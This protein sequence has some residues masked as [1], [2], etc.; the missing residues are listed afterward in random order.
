MS[1]IK[2]NLT[3]ASLFLVGFI[4]TGQAMSGSELFALKEDI[5]AHQKS[6]KKQAIYA[7]RKDGAIRLTT[8]QKP[9]SCQNP[10]F[11]Q[12]GDEVLF[13]RFIQGYNKGASEVIRLNLSSSSESVIVPASRIDKADLV[14][15]HW[16]EA[17]KEKIVFLPQ[18]QD[19]MPSLSPDLSQVVFESHQTEDK[20]SASDIWM[21]KSKD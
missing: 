2:K 1:N 13:I 19:S 15:S 9:A 10:I 11:S 8:C 20:N 12:S 14:Q 16:G 21:I 18:D 17:G 3:Q 4:F 7:K 6:A 5:Q